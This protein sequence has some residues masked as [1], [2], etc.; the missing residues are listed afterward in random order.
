M[1]RHRWGI[2][3]FLVSSVAVFSNAAAQLPDELPACPIMP[4]NQAEQE[5]YVDYEGLRYYFC[6]DACVN[7]FK[8]DPSRFTSLESTRGFPIPDGSVPPTDASVP[9]FEYAP[10]ET[11]FESC[12]SKFFATKRWIYR[13]YSEAHLDRPVLRWHVLAMALLVCVA[14]WRWR[15]RR[16]ASKVSS[17]GWAI[18]ILA[19]A[20][21][22]YWSW[23]TI[24]AEEARKAAIKEKEKAIAKLRAFDDDVV[25]REVHWSTF[26]DYGLP[27]RPRNDGKENSLSVT[28]YRGND[29]RS[30]QMFNG[31]QYR[32]VTF[33]VGLEN[34]AGKPIKYGQKFEGKPVY[35]K[36]SFVRSP[37]TSSGYFTSEYMRRMYLTMQAG[38]FNGRS[39]PVKDR[40]E[41][42]ETKPGLIW[43]ARFHL[44]SG[45]AFPATWNEDEPY[46]DNSNRHRGVVY[47]CEDRIQQDLVIGG[48]FHYAIEYDLQIENG[49]VG[50]ESDLFMGSTYSG[51]NFTRYR[52][53]DEQWLSRKP[54]PEKPMIEPDGS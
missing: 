43:E 17:I 6:C 42:I 34:E 28:Y 45:D 22:M 18:A 1:P 19:I 46:G 9:S 27:P 4:E 48:R 16:T 26:T 39:E 7:D 30:E 50:E 51:R 52:I 36:V 54:I 25:E 32:T 5:F 29:E 10:D 15:A 47:L 35:I 3:F 20:N 12:V 21:A 2:V 13:Q 24:E 49:I 41:W 8:S 33:H 14:L 37:D 40:V 11:F 31:G 23:A 38:R 44:P 53:T